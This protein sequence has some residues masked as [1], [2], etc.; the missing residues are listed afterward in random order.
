M[1]KNSAPWL[2]GV[3][4]K[5][6]CV[7]LCCVLKKHHRYDGIHQTRVQ[8][9]NVHKTLQKVSSSLSSAGKRCLS[10]GLCRPLRRT[11]SGSYCPSRELIASTLR[12][13]VDVYSKTLKG[14]HLFC[15]LFIAYQTPT[16]VA[17]SLWWVIVVS[18]KLVCALTLVCG[19]PLVISWWKVRCLTNSLVQ[20][21]PVISSQSSCLTKRWATFWMTTSARKIWACTRPGTTL[22]SGLEIVHQR[23]ASS[24]P[25]LS[26]DHATR[27]IISVLWTFS[28]IFV[29]Q[30][31]QMCFGIIFTT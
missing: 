19:N 18:M 4:V 17:W 26:L 10:V 30:E 31:I 16:L 1:K 15:I 2:S 22:L 13:F 12:I 20:F 23:L 5:S 21:F 29:F 28:K 25:W 8:L 6:V 3:E 11:F 24:T 27:A 9:K 14:S 7:C